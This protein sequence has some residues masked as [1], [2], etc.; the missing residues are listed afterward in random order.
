M[1]NE[2]DHIEDLFRRAAESYPLKTSGSNWNE[3]ASKLN[4]EKNKRDSPLVFFFNKN[5]FLLSVLLL[6]LIATSSYFLFTT[7]SHPTVSSKINEKLAGSQPVETTIRKNKS[8]NGNVAKPIKETALS[9]LIKDIASPL[10]YKTAAS[11]LVYRDKKIKNSKIAM[12]SVVTKPKTENVDS[13]NKVENNETIFYNTSIPLIEPYSSSIV[14]DFNS[15]EQRGLE[16]PSARQTIKE[17]ISHL[18][19]NK[20]WTL[21]FLAGVDKSNIKQQKYSN[22]G[23]SFGATIAYSI[24]HWLIE[25]G[26]IF[27]KKNYYSDGKYFNPKVAI[28][29]YWKITSLNGNCSMFEIPLN[30]GYSLELNSK[31]VIAFKSG[32]SSY[33]MNR[34]IYDYKYT[35][36]GLTYPGTANYKSSIKN[37]FAVSNFSVNYSHRINNNTAFGLEPYL[38]IPVQ[39]IGTGRMPISSYGLNLLI[40]KKF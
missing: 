40:S 22:S 16:D 26:L 24:N 18:A 5:K 17:K 27:D 32:F 35:S 21:S 31:N 36:Y 14:S 25:T 6:I 29:P 39:N 7:K 10:N 37:W 1:P 19:A 2:N 34:E 28:N 9:D 15:K 3:V 11:H 8:I 20:K 13:T 23:S 12:S 30:I 38:K 4:F 33:L